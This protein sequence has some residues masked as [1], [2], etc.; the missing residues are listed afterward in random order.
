[1]NR[2]G[3]RNTKKNGG[4]VK[5]NSHQAT[6][7]QLL[8]PGMLA[9]AAVFGGYWI[10]RQN[11]LVF[12]GMAELFSIAIAWSV[13]SLVWNARKHTGD[14]FLLFI[15]IAYAFVGSIDLVHALA[16]KGMGVFPGYDANLPTQLWIAAR[17]MESISLVMAPSML[18][19]RFRPGLLLSVYAAATALVFGTTLFTDLFP[20]CYVEGSGLTSFKKASEYLICGMLAAAGYR[21]SAKKGFIHKRLHRIMLGAIA[22]TILAELSFTFYVSVYGLSNFIGHMMKI[23]SFFLIYKAVV[24]FGI[25]QPFEFLIAKEK[26]NERQLQQERDQLRKA[27]AEIKTLSGLLPICASCKKIRDDTGY[28]ERIEKYVERNST[29]KFTHGICPDCEQRLYSMVQGPQ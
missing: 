21:M 13:F 19:R 27:L 15:G 16:Y 2:R 5:P 23:F 10:S 12:H 26:E 22:T 25:S 1:M 4:T 11:Y 6:I 20:A 7:R 28:W 18:S 9:M 17:Y 3:M 8:K 29:A 14:G 24:E